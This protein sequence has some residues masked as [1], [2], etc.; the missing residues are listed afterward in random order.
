MLVTGALFSED[1]VS[2]KKRFSE[3]EAAYAIGHCTHESQLLSG[4]W[5]KV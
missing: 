2:A 5:N 3:G 1:G 4:K